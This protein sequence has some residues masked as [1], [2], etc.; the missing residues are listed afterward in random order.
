MLLGHHTHC[1]HTSRSYQI[2]AGQTTAEQL[3]PALV[4]AAL[5]PGAAPI[6]AAAG[7][8]PGL[9]LD[10]SIRINLLIVVYTM[11]DHYANTKYITPMS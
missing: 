9:G 6:S 3:G 4:H 10:N 5:H 8:V 2:T 11:P 1:S 7:A